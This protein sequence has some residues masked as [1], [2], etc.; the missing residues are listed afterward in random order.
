MHKERKL[1]TVSPMN[2][3]RVI[4]NPESNQC[5]LE[6]SHSEIVFLHLDVFDDTIAYQNIFDPLDEFKVFSHH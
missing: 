3:K 2:E 5:V 1:H 6:I 4:I